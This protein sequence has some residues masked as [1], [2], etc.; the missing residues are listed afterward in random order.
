MYVCVH[1]IIVVCVMGMFGYKLQRIVC[2]LCILYIIQFKK[3]DIILCIQYVVHNV[4]F[5]TMYS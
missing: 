2:S 5:F 1:C 3:S 4:Y